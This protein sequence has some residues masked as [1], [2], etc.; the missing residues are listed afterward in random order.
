MVRRFDSNVN[1]R[2]QSL[3]PA[4]SSWARSE[5]HA[6][7]APELSTALAFDMWA[8]AVAQVPGGNGVFPVDLG[9]ALF[10]SRALRR[11]LASR[12]LGEGVLPGGALEG[13]A[14]TVRRAPTRPWRVH[15][16]WVRGRLEVGE[17]GLD[18]P[19]TPEETS[20]ST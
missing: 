1:G 13:L 19:R 17:R 15:A 14:Q 12:A 8:H 20:R 3:D 16:R 18:P 4:W 11:H 9:E 10:A 2:G 5:V 7:G 6:S